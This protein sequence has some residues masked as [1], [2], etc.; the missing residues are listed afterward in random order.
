MGGI[1]RVVI[2]VNKMDTMEW[3][4]E[5]YDEIKTR[6]IKF[7]TEDIGFKKKYVDVLPLSG[8]MKTNISKETAV[9]KEVC[10]W[11]FGKPTLLETLDGLKKVKRSTSEPLRV[12]VLDRYKGDRGLQAIGKVE[13]GVIRTGDE[14]KIIPTEA[15]AKIMSLSVDDCVVEAAG[16]G[17]NVLITFDSRAL[18]MDAI[19]SGCAICSVAEPAKICEKFTAEIYIHELPG[20]GIMTRGYQSMF[21]CHNV[22]MLCEVETLLHKLH[23]KTRKRSKVA[24]SF[25]RA[26]D[27][28]IAVITLPQRVA[29]EKFEECAAFGRF[30]LRDQGKT[31][32]IGKIRE[33][34]ESATKL[35]TK[36]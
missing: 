8:Q 3:S 6:T 4:K 1:S 30:T 20:A 31:V 25:L 28:A 13:A 2:V 14:V 35:K 32:V 36:R 16:A 29:L 10:P 22:S 18:S 33:I 12:P 34:E 15:T 27:N 24:P 17:E 9:T 19:Y 7:L 26:K 23:R 21:H 11:Y 5:R